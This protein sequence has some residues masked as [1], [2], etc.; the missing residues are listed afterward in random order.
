MKKRLALMAAALLCALPLLSM[1]GQAEKLGSLRV[2][3]FK[4]GKADAY[5][6]RTDQ[7]S[8]MIDAGEE[9][10]AQE[11]IDYLRNR[12]I[13]E[14]DYLILSHFDKR[15]VGGAEEFL[16]AIR[17]KQIL[18]PDYPKDN[19]RT[20]ALFELM[21]RM[22]LSR[23]T[24]VTRFSL[25]S[26]DFVIYPARGV[27]YEEDED[28]DFSLVVSVAH[29]K[30]S[31]LFPG[32]IMSVRIGEMIASGEL[33]P[34]TFLKM[35]AHGQNIPGLAALLDAVKPEVALIPCSA[36]NPPAGAVTADLEARGIRWYAT[37]D[38]AVSLTSDGYALTAKQTMKDKDAQ[39]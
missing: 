26:V 12:Q 29:G 32:D 15:S 23:V 9:D 27:A 36:K 38:G 4:I 16:G 3:C 1:G 17:A 20:Q 25:D 5:F 33:A 19:P 37:K 31:L 10:D 7:H 11:L 18:V 39:E 8:L 6:L 28:N 14:I 24:Q 35:P 22:Q 13:E 30:N 34:H 2:K 21:D